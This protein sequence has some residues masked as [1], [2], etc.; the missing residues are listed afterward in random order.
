MFY[1][2]G[3]G[4][5]PTASAVVGDVMDIAKH[6]DK[7]V[8][9]MWTESEDGYLLDSTQRKSKFFVRIKAEQA[10]EC[11]CIENSCTIDGEM[12]LIVSEKTKSELV[13]SLN[14]KGA[15][16]LSIIKLVK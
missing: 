4:M 11:A 16:A 10:F 13:D 15:E 1:G 7:N 5:L 3:A 8:G 2:R 9:I 12:G 14:A 6:Q